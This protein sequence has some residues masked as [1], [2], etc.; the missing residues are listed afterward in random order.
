MKYRSY[1]I[2]ISLG[3]QT[4]IKMKSN[5]LQKKKM[6]SNLK[7]CHFIS[8]VSARYGAQISKHKQNEPEQ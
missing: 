6:K 8:L 5:L 2:L 3:N 7:T 4:R 1:V